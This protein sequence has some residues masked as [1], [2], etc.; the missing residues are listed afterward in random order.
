M[1]F[2]KDLSSAKIS[3][4]L[5]VALSGALIVT[6]AVAQSFDA[7]NSGLNLHD[8]A[9][10]LPPIT[11]YASPSSPENNPLIQTRELDLKARLVENGHDIQTGLVWRVFS[12]TVGPDGQLPLIASAQGG[13]AV[14]NLPEGSYL[15][16]VAYGRAGA[17]KR[18]TLG[19]NI[20]HEVMTLDAGGVK[21]SAGLPDG[22]KINEKLLR[23]SIYAGEDTNERSLILPDVQPNSIIRLNSGTYHVVSNYGSANASIR[24]DIR[25]EAGKLTEAAVQ[26]HAAEVTLKLVRERG[27]EALADTS[28]SI[29]NT[30]GD[31]ITESVGAYS[32][33]VLIEGEYVAVAKNK[34]RIY[35]REFKVSSGKNEEV[36][37]IANSE[38]EAPDDSVD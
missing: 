27:G 2:F 30:A 38:N 37:V 3:K 35:Q 5:G 22:G 16:H 11:P 7:T 33:M 19:N 17:T 34:D 8:P 36:E 14:F 28:W 9:L 24:A 26:H 15:V 20:R 29:T 13:N 10:K 4:A 32:S 6:P 31:A 18:I 23:F 1:L 21:L 12:P 25:V